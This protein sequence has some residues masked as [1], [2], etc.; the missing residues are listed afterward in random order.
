MF[1]N[2]DAHGP[3]RQKVSEKISINAEAKEVWNIVKDFK[4]FKW[5]PSI[6]N[7]KASDNKIGSER[8]LEFQ[9]GYSVKQKLEKIDDKKQY[10]SWRI[11]ETSNEIMPV[12]SYAAK[13]FVK[14]KENGTT[15]VLYKAG[16]YRGFMGND[17]PEELNDENSKKKVSD[18]IIN[19]LKGLKVIAENK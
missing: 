12:N 15:E 1:K 3:S 9:K 10:I 18:F 7:V 14:D 4:N 11:I 5:N 16:F 2:T 13:I 6:K 17:P 8:Q 19:S